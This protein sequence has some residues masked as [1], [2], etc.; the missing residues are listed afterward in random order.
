M[1]L[2][3]LL[4]LLHLLLIKKH[5]WKHITSNSENTRGNI[6]TC[7]SVCVGDISST[8]WEACPRIMTLYYLN[9]A[10]VKIRWLYP[11]NATHHST[12]NRHGVLGW[13]RA[14]ED[15]R[16]VVIY[17]IDCMKEWDRVKYQNANHNIW[18][19]LRLNFKATRSRIWG[20][21]D[22]SSRSWNMRY[23][24]IVVKHFYTITMK[25][26]KI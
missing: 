26:V 11:G 20:V 23:Y 14:V 4:I 7:I 18:G 10:F 12:P 3:S 21:S 16:W 5:N 1:L 13:L 22:T 19:R 25:Q 6:A 8:N 2:L 9:A 15:Y 17:L 24:A